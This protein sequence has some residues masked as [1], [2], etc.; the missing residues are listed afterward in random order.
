MSL[1]LNVEILGEYK[2][3]SKATDGAGQ[4]FGKL[5]TKFATVGKNIAKVVGG[6]G[7]GLAAAA[8]SQIRP[9][10]EAAS[11]LAEATNAVQVAFGK[12]SDGIIDLGKTS[13]KEL[14]ISK[15]DLYGI[16][17]QLSGIAKKIA[18][19]S[20]DVV[21]IVDDLSTRAADFASVFNLDVREALGKFQSGLS[22][23]SEPLRNFGIDLSD[24]A[25][26]A[27]GL[28]SGIYDGEG[29][30]TESEKTMARYGLLMHETDQVSGDFA[31]TSGSL[32]NQQRILEASLE[33]VRAEIGEKF[34]PILSDF[35]SFILENVI[36]AVEDFWANLTDPNGEAM[37]QIGA[38]GDAWAE[39]TSVF[40]I[41]SGKIKSND[42]FKWMGDSVISVIK[43]MTNMATFFSEIGQ[44][45]EKM[46][47][48]GGTAALR[49]EGIQQVLGA[50]GKAQAAS[51][52]IKFADQIMPKSGADAARKAANSNINVN[53]N[54]ATVNADQIVR[55]INAKLKN[56]GSAVILR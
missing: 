34:M 25:V 54:R 37:S 18:G 2:N 44:G 21:E 15:T 24:A 51:D 33:D 40:T 42:I 13:A 6:V 12:A 29:A 23:Q 28:E 56:Q 16:S 41:E 55:D 47:R 5:G 48:D 10:I 19:E 31:N 1:V 4:T 32:A 8:A 11:D 17:T 3:L 38:L 46:G 22:G 36:P 7:L 39:F 50:G 14:G 43:L 49:L 30:M 26:K 53:I 35:M 52:R 9:A 45:M 20:G 27:Y